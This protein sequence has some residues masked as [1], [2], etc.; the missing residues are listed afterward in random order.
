MAGQGADSSVGVEEAEGGALK[1]SGDQDHDGSVRSAVR[2]LICDPAPI[3]FPGPFG[4]HPGHLDVWWQA[5]GG[6]ANAD[7]DFDDQFPG[8]IG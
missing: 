6:I 5:T 1:V 3:V 2:N 4:P 7:G 8:P